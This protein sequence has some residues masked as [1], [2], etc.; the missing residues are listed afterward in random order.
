MN[1][2]KWKR[3]VPKPLSRRVLA[4][5]ASMAAP[6]LAWQESITH[7]DIRPPEGSL[8]A[9]LEDHSFKV[10]TNGRE[11]AVEDVTAHRRR[12]EKP[13]Y[14]RG[15]TDVPQSH[16]LIGRGVRLLLVN[17]CKRTQLPIIASKRRTGR[18]R[19]SRRSARNVTV[20]QGQ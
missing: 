9:Q 1:P 2:P 12:L 19:S 20:T 8:R 4:S 10:L 3:L 13:L 5:H 15:G 7:C 14:T 17:A 16:G 11:R 18:T 6:F